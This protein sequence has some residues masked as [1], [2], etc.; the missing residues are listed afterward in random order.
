M[1]KGVVMSRGNYENRQKVE[2]K[3]KKK[4]KNILYNIDE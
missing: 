4:K 2:K 1:S 3:E